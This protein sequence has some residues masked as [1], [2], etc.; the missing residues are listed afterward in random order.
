[1]TSKLECD[2]FICNIMYSYII[3]V[4]FKVKRIT[5]HAIMNVHNQQYNIVRS[6]RL[7][8]H[9]VGYRSFSVTVFSSMLIHFVIFKSQ[10]F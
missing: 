3:I 6:N 5:G 10:F 7:F 1:M 2:D 9:S 4:I 8:K